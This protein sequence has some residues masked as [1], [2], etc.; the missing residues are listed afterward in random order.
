MLYAEGEVQG[1]MG[2]EESFVKKEG[3]LKKQ[4]EGYT[5]PHRSRSCDEIHSTW[6]ARI[7]EQ[8]PAHEPPPPQAPA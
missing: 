4:F 2:S 7:I 3:L 1:E 8:L 6:R 5:P